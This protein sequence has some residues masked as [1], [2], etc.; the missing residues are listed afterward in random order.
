MPLQVFLTGHHLCIV[1]EYA[2]GGELFERILRVGRFSEDET[3]YYFQQLIS[4]VDFC[5][6][7]VRAPSPPFVPCPRLAYVPGPHMPCPAP[8]HAMC[9]C[10]TLS[11]GI[12]SLPPRLHLSPLP[13]ICNPNPK[14]CP[15]PGNLPPRP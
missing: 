10:R 13:G 4:G 7:S 1:M 12:T 8:C 9:Y 11:L 5:H 3:R 14:P 2:A 6:R 15:L